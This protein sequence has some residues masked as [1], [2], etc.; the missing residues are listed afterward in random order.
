MKTI[1]VVNTVKETTAQYIERINQIMNSVIHEDHLIRGM[2]HP[3]QNITE[4][5]TEI[6]HHIE[7]TEPII[8][9]VTFKD[10]MIRLPGVEVHMAKERGRIWVIDHT[11]HA[12][13]DPGRDPDQDPGRDPG[14]DPGQKRALVT[15]QPIVRERENHAHS[16]AIL[17]IIQKM[18]MKMVRMVV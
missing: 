12:I 1:H 9:K 2:L 16:G 6:S 10:G 11:S 7:K 14:Q 15:I 17:I 3:V 5:F 18:L 4:M 8:K 13:Q